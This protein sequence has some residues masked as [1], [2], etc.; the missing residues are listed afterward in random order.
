MKKISLLSLVAVAGIA[1]TTSASA[2]NMENPLYMPKAG[3]AFISAEMNYDNTE[4]KAG[5]TDP[6][7]VSVVRNDDFEA[8]EWQDSFTLGYG[9]S[10]QFALTVSNSDS[11]GDSI[12]NYLNTNQAIA[13]TNSHRAPAPVVNGIFR[14]VKNGNVVLDVVGSINPALQHNEPL[15]LGAGIRAGVMTKK[16]TLAFGG[17]VGYGMSYDAIDLATGSDAGFEVDDNMAYTL[18]GDFQFNINKKMSF[19]LGAEYTI[20]DEQE[21]S[22]AGGSAKLGEITGYNIELGLNIQTKKMLITPYI[23]M[24]D[25]EQDDLDGNDA[26]S[27]SG[28]LN[29]D[30]LEASGMSYG[31]RFGLEF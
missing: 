18:T 15:T 4:V 1:Y 29:G 6:G 27:T 11:T 10:N 22:S 13:W 3:T 5:D 24:T 16:M 21:V 25:F 9:F 14:A 8:G 17:Y 2:M 28:S 23:A 31:V 12:P 7:T 20:I 19:N 30:G 26:A